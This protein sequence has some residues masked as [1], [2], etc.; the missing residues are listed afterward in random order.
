MCGHDYN[1][2]FFRHHPRCATDVCMIHAI[3]GESTGD[4]SGD[5]SGDWQQHSDY[6]FR[7]TESSVTILQRS[8]RTLLLE[9]FRLLVVG[10]AALDS[11]RVPSV[12]AQQSSRMLLQVSN[13]NG[14]SLSF[15]AYSTLFR[16]WFFLLLS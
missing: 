10:D 16:E 7:Y 2:L 15:D 3:T 9:I 8:C 4:F 1:T 5:F 12:L 11:G 6:R 13:D 14:F